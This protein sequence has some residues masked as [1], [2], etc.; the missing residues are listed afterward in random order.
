[1]F[2]KN[3]LKWWECIMKKMKF[4]MIWI[5]ILLI[6]LSVPVDIY[7]NNKRPEEKKV[8]KIGVYENRPMMYIDEDGE[9]TGFMIDV[10]NYIFKKEGYETEFVEGTLDASFNRLKAG[11][12]DMV[13]SLAYSRE[14][15]EFC[16][17]TDET[18]IVNWGELYVC[19][20]SEI[21]TVL[22][23]RGKK[24]GVQ[25]GDLHYIGENGIRR[26]LEKLEIGAQ[27]VEYDYKSDIFKD[28]KDGKLDAGFVNRIYGLNK[29]GEYDL[30]ATSIIMNPIELKMAIRADL[31]PK[32]KEDFDFWLKLLKGKE[33]SYYYEKMDY[34]MSGRKGF[35]VPELVKKSLV[36]GAISILL[37]TCLVL[38]S[39]RQVRQKT[40]ELKTLNE[41]LNNLNLELKES[42]EN[43]ETYNEELIALNDELE[44]SYSSAHRTKRKLKELIKLIKGLG[45]T[46]VRD[47]DGFMSN[48]INTG[49][50]FVEEADY[51]LAMALG[52]DFEIKGMRC[53]GCT[54]REG[55]KYIFNKDK[56]YD[57][58][59]RRTRNIFISHVNP[60]DYIDGLEDV[61]IEEIKESMV[62]PLNFNDDLIGLIIMSVKSDSKKSFSDSSLEIMESFRIIIESFLSIQNYHTRKESIQK[63]IILAMTNILEIHDEYTKG[64]SEN[65]ANLA[66]EIG[67]KMDLCK[68]E[69]NEI[70]WAGMVHDVGKVIIPRDILNKPSRLSD[71]EF[72][73]IKKHPNYGF[74]A[75]CHS[76]TL[77]NISK[78]ILMHHERWD[79]RGYPNGLRGKEIS[80][81]ASIIAIADTWDAMTSD[82]SYRKGMNHKDAR[83]EI[84]RGRG[85]QFDPE[86]ADVFLDM[87]ESGFET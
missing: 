50:S 51:G 26:T 82:R 42:Y 79:G 17:F 76:P 22:D 28:V 15:S 58:K 16:D 32:I 36:I 70:Y 5:A 64:H 1:M 80:R 31:D 84:V 25:K 54:L 49:L 30:K 65:V 11:G 20:K 61:D 73:E 78:D 77:K 7:A 38:I 69:L 87:L 4:S 83:A 13:P 41:D 47:E 8:I 56:Y 14:R 21:K 48:I 24:I 44:Q 39:K 43:L 85:S 35:S 72:D 66:V 55:Q 52:E 63:E 27:L 86:I 9:A 19:K 67:K 3:G 75:L 6:V 45:D 81:A 23:L 60:S 40:A 57:L 33:N 74:S 2:L 62:I 34:Y 10:I 59:R 18:F 71:E 37:L 29:M 12:V 46:S 68:N 53:I